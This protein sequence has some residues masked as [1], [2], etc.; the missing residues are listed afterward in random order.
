MI[1]RVNINKWDIYYKKMESFPVF[2]YHCTTVFEIN[3]SYLSYKNSLKYHYLQ[4]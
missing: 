3:D 1:T 2:P 4:Y